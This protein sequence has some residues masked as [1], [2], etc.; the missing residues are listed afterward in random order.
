MRVSIFSTPFR[1][2]V[3]KHDGK[4]QLTAIWLSV[5]AYIRSSESVRA[6]ANRTIRSASYSSSWK[7]WNVRDSSV[8]ENCNARYILI[9]NRGALFWGV[10]FICTLMTKNTRNTKNLFLVIFHVILGIIGIIGTATKDINLSFSCSN[11]V[12]Q[13]T[14]VPCVSPLFP[15][16]SIPSSAF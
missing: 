7:I 1:F 15:H 11:L 12:E 10:L 16:C 9:A 8:L 14:A 6:A 13:Q 3:V 5:T 2:K 4:I